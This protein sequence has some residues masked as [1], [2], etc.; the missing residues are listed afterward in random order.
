M[1]LQVMY[2]SYDTERDSKMETLPLMYWNSK[3]IKI[4]MVQDLV[5]HHQKILNS[6]SSDII[7]VFKFL[8]FF[9][10]KS[11]FQKIKFGLG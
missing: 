7:A 2:N 8:F 4:Q 10:L 6:L 9:K 3:C 5:S 11:I 1:V